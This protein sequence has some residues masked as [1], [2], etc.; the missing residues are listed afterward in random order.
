M[1]R[2]L[3]KRAGAAASNDIT[4]HSLTARSG[5]RLQTGSSKALRGDHE[6]DSS[7]YTKTDMSE[8]A[9]LCCKR[10]KIKRGTTTLGLDVDAKLSALLEAQCAEGQVGETASVY[11]PYQSP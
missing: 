6:N 11:L 2:A 3:P 10:I 1:R 5:K 9:T 4:Q 7:T 8:A